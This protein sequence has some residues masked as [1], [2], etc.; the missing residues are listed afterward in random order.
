MSRPFA[1]PSELV[2]FMQEDVPEDTAR[3]NLQVASAAVRGHVRWCLAGEFVDAQRVRVQ[4]GQQSIWLPTLHL[5]SVVLLLAGAV[6]LVDGSQFDW[7]TEGRV[8]LRTGVWASTVYTISY[9]HGFLDDHE[10]IGVA[11]GVVLAAA[12]RLCDNPKSHGSESSGGESMVADSAGLVLSEGDR[13]QLDPW[14]L[15]VLG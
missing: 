5:R 8:T 12:A 11:K 9:H 15:P 6:P 1:V 4:P 10:A 14:V 3:L 13:K 7:Y 2:S